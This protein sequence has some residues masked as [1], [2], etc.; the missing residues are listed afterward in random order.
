MIITAHEFLGRPYSEMGWLQ[1]TVT[2]YADS[3]GLNLCLTPLALQPIFCKR[4][5]FFPR[6]HKAYSLVQAYAPNR[7]TQPSPD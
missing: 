7:T 2:M 1:T 5:N 3:S 4:Y 6:S